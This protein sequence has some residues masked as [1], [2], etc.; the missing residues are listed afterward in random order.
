MFLYIES[1]LLV[2]TYHSIFCKIL[3]LNLCMDIQYPSTM[4]CHLI[5]EVSVQKNRAKITYIN[6]TQGRCVCVVTAFESGGS[7]NYGKTWPEIE[8]SQRSCENK[9]LFWKKF[10]CIQN[11]DFFFLMKHMMMIFKGC[12]KF[13]D[14][15]FQFR[16]TDTN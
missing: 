16:F 3:S 7:C 14:R 1:R 10:E 5:I 4:T 6:I 8:K 15:C 9:I 12:V 2:S 11:F 13:V